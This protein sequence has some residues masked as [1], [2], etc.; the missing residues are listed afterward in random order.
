MRPES[1]WDGTVR[2]L[3]T[4]P[5]DGVTNMAIDEALL[6][7]SAESGDT[8][9]RVYA[10]ERP[11]VSFGRN[12]RC[13]GIYDAA[14]CEAL[15]IPAVRRLTGG[16]ALLHAREVTYSVTAPTRRAPTLRG[17]YEAINTLLLDAL[18][19]M[20]VAAAPAVTTGRTPVPGLAPC[21]ETPSAG[22]LAV[23]GRKLVG[24]AQHREADAFLQHGSIL[25]ANDQGLLDALALVPLPAVPQPATLG[26][27]LDGV[28]AGTVADAIEAAVRRAAGVG[29]SRLSLHEIPPHHVEAAC[30]RYRDSG[31]TWRR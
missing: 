6:R 2:L 4:P 13:A 19:A 9:V 31:W 26:A 28:T 25:L 11:T 10:W 16:R 3:R 30:S 20:G 21:F 7:L 24:S 23:H 12:Q 14:R 5:L 8:V 1:L 17:G 22:E 18:Q 27:C 29:V 15:G